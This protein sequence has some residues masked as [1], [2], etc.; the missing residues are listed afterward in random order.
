MTMDLIEAFLLTLSVAAAV[1]L[2]CGLPVFVVIA[3][4]SM[5]RL[6]G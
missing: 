1:I 4:E 2:V 5:E 3:L 6:D